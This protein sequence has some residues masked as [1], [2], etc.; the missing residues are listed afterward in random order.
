MR[1]RIALDTSRGYPKRY[2]DSRLYHHEPKDRPFEYVYIVRCYDTSMIGQ[3]KRVIQLDHLESISDDSG[4]AGI[5]NEDAKYLDRTS[6]HVVDRT[7]NV[8]T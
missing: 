8:S 3:C 4:G 1:K 7:M 2:H 5:T 6:V